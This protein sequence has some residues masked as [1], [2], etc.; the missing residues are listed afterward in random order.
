MPSLDFLTFFSRFSHE[1]TGEISHF[2]LTPIGGEN[3]KNSLTTRRRKRLAM[4]TLAPSPKTAQARVLP[5]GVAS[6]RLSQLSSF[7][8]AGEAFMLMYF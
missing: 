3:E 8:R 5:G 7:S 4:P 2:S 6:R 1:K